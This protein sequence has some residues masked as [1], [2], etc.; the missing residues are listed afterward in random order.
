MLFIV[1]YSLYH[2]RTTIVAIFLAYPPKFVDTL[3]RLV[4]RDYM[5][6]TVCVIQSVMGIDSLL[7][8]IRLHALSFPSWK[9]GHIL[10][11]PNWSLL[12]FVSKITCLHPPPFS[13]H[14]L[15]QSSYCTAFSIW[16]MSLLHDA[17]DAAINRYLKLRPSKFLQWKMWTNAPCLVWLIKSS[18]RTYSTPNSI[19]TVGRTHK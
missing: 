13:K 16:T 12:V 14:R 11:V 7:L 5:C 19:V 18:C 3:K 4:H 10:Q 8:S 6:T 9:L 1:D 15:R 17:A 2:V